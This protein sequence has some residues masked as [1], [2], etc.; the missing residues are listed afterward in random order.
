MTIMTNLGPYTP[1]SLEF[2]RRLLEQSGT[3]DATHWP[4]G[5]VRCLE[6]GVKA[7]ISV[8]AARYGLTGAGCTSVHG[9]VG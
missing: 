6:K 8:E 9:R 3:G 4:P 7:D 2:M 1:E 5:T